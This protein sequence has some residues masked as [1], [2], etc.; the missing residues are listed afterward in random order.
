MNDEQ[1]KQYIMQAIEFYAEKY[2]PKDWDFIETANEGDIRITADFMNVKE[3]LLILTID[4]QANVM[5]Q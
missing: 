4:I 3:E 5:R 1:A 2:P